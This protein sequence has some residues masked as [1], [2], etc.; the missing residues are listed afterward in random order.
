MLSRAGPRA[1]RHGARGRGR[2]ARAVRSCGLLFAGLVLVTVGWPR[3]A[4]AQ[5]PEGAPAVAGN[6]VVRENQLP[7]DRDWYVAAPARAEAVGLAPDEGDQSTDRPA[8][9]VWTAAP[10]EGYADRVSVERG[11]TIGFYVST[12][13]PAFDLSVSRMGWYG[14]QG[15]RTM[16]R[17][18][19]LPGEAQP[20]PT[21]EPATG[22]IAADW[23]LSYSLRVPHD[24][25]S[26]VYLARLRAAGDP[27]DEAH[28]LFVVRHDAQIADFVYKLPLNT[29]QA[30]N[31]WGGKSLYAFNSAGEPATK[32][33]FD[34]PYA[35]RGGAGHFFHW[36]Y[37][38]IRWL[39]REG[40]N[41][42]YITDMDAHADSDYLPGRRALLSVGHDEYWSK[43]MRDSWEDARDAG[44]SLG[45]FGANSAYW[46]VRHESSARGIPHRVLVCYKHHAPDPLAGADPSRATVLWRE[47]ALGRPENALVGVMSEGMIPFDESYPY[48]VR[49]ADHWIF[50]G[51]GAQPGEA[52]SRI[53]GYEY[54]R[55]MENGATP[56]GLVVLAE[57]PLVDSTGKPSVSHSTYYQQGGMVFAA[58]TVDWAWAL[59]DYWRPGHV[60]A[61]LQR[62]TANLLAAFRA[63]APPVAAAPR[64]DRSP[65]PIYFGAA[66]IALAAACV[67]LWLLVRRTRHECG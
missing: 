11:G 56:A 61:R 55:L 60:D 22:L 53:V 8:N 49:A 23:R 50:A 52:W 63:G 31:N 43:A 59:D 57:S 24:W 27:P 21:P 4:A 34:R 14:G 7:G 45:F 3:A 66:A 65:A 67:P 1:G 13:A 41:V 25:P 40:Y 48:V 10:I 58:G 6:V 5:A 64:A 39:E 18:Q 17:A 35:L 33:S 51:T 26:G 12:S 20:V 28:I 42:T 32:V 54:D 30:Y 16:H 29:Y 36:D 2:P 44:Y 15:G 9:E 38:M 47:A 62:V 46:Q 37:P 19:G